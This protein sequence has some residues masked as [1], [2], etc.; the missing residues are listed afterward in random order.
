MR[1]WKYNRRIRKESKEK[2]KEINAAGNR[3]LQNVEGALTCGGSHTAVYMY[4]RVRPPG[5]LQRPLGRHQRSMQT[6]GCMICRV[7]DMACDHAYTI[8]QPRRDLHC[9][10][11]VLL[12][13]Q[14][15]GE[16]KCRR[17]RPIPVIPAPCQAMNG[18]RP[19]SQQGKVKTPWS[20]K[21]NKFKRQR[22]VGE[23]LDSPAQLRYLSFSKDGAGEIVAMLCEPH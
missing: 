3:K 19:R 5:P 10:Q 6:D 22:K 13:R 8:F 2:E 1:H 18:Q 14:V 21:R 12:G 20:S 23:S 4:L 15:V 16:N 17:R 11:K 7:G 9:L